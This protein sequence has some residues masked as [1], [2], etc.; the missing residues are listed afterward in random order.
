MKKIIVLLAIFAINVFSLTIKLNSTKENKVRYAILHIVNDTPFMCKKRVIDIAHYEFICKIAGNSNSLKIS[1][2]KT[3]FVDIFLNN[4]KNYI[5]II[6]KPKYQTRYY[7]VDKPLYQEKVVDK[8]RRITSK[9]WIFIFYKDSIFLKEAPKD[10]GIDFPIDFIQDATPSIGALD[11]SGIPVSY[12]ND[13]KDINAYISIKDDYDKQRYAFVIEESKKA[14]KNY[15]NSMFANDFILYRIRAIYKLL[16]NTKDPLSQDLSYDEIIKL[17]KKWIKKYS[18]NQNIPEVLYYIAT[19]YQNLGQNSDAKYFFDILI[20]EH[21]KNRW[22]KLG[23]ISFADSLYAQ[24]K[25]QKAIELYKDVL[26]S[27]KDL[28]VASIAAKKLAQIYLKQKQYKKAALYY[29]KIIQANPDFFLKDHQKAYDLAMNLSA[30]TLNKPAIKILEKLL[31]KL[32]REPDLKEMVIKS[33]GDLYAKEKNYKKA[34]FYYKMYI[35]LYRYG[36]YIDEVKKKLDGLFFDTDEKNETKLLKYYDK[37]IDRYKAGKIY[38]KAIILKAKLL[39]KQKRYKQVLALLNDSEVSAKNKKT[40]EAIKKEAA[41]KIAKIALSK[42]NCLEAIKYIKEYKLTI[43]TDQENLAKCYLQTYQYKKAITL[44]KQMLNKELGSVEEKLFWMDIE[45]KSFLKL[46]QFDKLDTLSEDLITLS[47]TFDNK[48]YLKKGLYYRFFALYGLKKYNKAIAVAQNNIDKEFKD[49]F[50]NIEIYKN[51]VTLAR[52]RADYLMVSKYAK[53]IIELQKKYNSYL[54]TPWIEFSYIASLK[55]LG[56]DSQALE[57][58]QD[59]LKRVKKAS[60]KARV[61][62]EIGSIYLKLNKKDRAKEAFEKCINIKDKNSWKELCTEGL[63][64]I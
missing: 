52:K 44:S 24:N 57:L 28:Q 33:L 37:L 29:D 15:P 20:T 59:M 53:K 35:S 41:L 5:Q 18:S 16:S 36:N 25:E 26:Y 27:T 60:I 13:S 39:L 55:H 45:A 21:P 58:L 12:L 8:N 42:Q 4:K 38:E 2:K 43:K 49:S 31:Q 17:G 10:I 19:A 54:L 3:K 40:I 50:D 48:I 64:L 63:G 9:H 61:Y 46:R 14:L 56:K 30:N 34:S 23:I 1:P 6:L 62:Y 51:I 22:T 47:K 11:L 32:K 7:L